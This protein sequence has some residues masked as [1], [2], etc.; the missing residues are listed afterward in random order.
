MGIQPSLQ[1]EREGGKVGGKSDEKG[2]GDTESDEEE[3]KHSNESS[4]QEGA[5]YRS[6]TPRV[7]LNIGMIESVDAR[8]ALLAS[9]C[10]NDEVRDIAVERLDAA[11]SMIR[12]ALAYVF[13]LLFR[14]DL[15]ADNIPFSFSSSLIR[16]QVLVCAPVR[17]L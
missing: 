7:N 14:L 6:T 15:S 4:V 2:E 5:P 9:L 3:G 1:M 16:I 11:K 10:L 12:V 17:Q 13:F 8:A